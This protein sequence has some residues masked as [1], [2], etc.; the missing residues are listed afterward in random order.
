MRRNT[1]SPDARL[2]DASHHGE[3]GE[4]RHVGENGADAQATRRALARTLGPAGD[5]SGQT[6]GGTQQPGTRHGAIDGLT[7]QQVARGSPRGCRTAAR[8]FWRTFCRVMFVRFDVLRGE[9]QGVRCVQRL[10]A[11]LQ[12]VVVFFIIDHPNL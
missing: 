3:T 7:P 11:F 8:Q 2:D 10:K 1:R 9:G 5:G 4:R 6:K 12:I